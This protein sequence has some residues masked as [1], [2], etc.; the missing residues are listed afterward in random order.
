MKVCDRCKKELD[1]K[2]SSCLNGKTFE[3]CSSCADYI[4]NHI[5]NYKGKQKSGIG[6]LFG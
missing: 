2:K 4:A 3:L 5:E 6:K 1:T